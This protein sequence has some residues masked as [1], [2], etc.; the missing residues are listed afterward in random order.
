MSKSRRDN[1]G[2]TREQRL[3]HENDKLKKQISGLR[4]QL[5]RI[6]LDRSANVR[7]IVQKYYEQEDKEA[8]AKK[9]QESLE[10]LQREWQCSACGEG[11]LEINLL[12]KLDVLNYYRKCTCCP[13]RTKLQVY[14]KQVRGIIKK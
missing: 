14:N 13:N 7:D 8:F 9:E 1:R 2:N 5:A 6:D 11:Y 12:N 10:A 3:Q 4:K